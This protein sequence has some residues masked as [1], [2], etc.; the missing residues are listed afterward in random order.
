MGGACRVDDAITAAIRGG[1]T[2]CVSAGRMRGLGTVAVLAILG[3]ARTA[4]LILRPI[5]GP[6][7]II[8]RLAELVGAGSVREA[9]PI[10]QGAPPWRRFGAIR[11]LRAIHAL[12]SCR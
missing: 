7:R 9:R 11:R 2:P 1:P 6:P 3:P 5:G 12:T 4:T 8:G 10:E